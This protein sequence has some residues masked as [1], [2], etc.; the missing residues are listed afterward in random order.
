[1]EKSTGE[2][3]SWFFGDWIQTT[4]RN[5]LALVKASQDKG[6]TVKNIGN[7]PSSANISAMQGDSVLAVVDV[8]L[9]AP[10]ARSTVDAP[11]VSGVDRWVLDEERVTLD[12]DRSNNVRQVSGLFKGAEPLQ[13]RMLTRLENPDKTQVFWLPALGW[14]AHNGLMAGVTLHNMAL[15]PRDF[16]YQWTPLFSVREF[17]QGVD[18]GGILAMDWRK[19]QWHVGMRSSQFRADEAMQLRPDVSIPQYDGALLTRTSFTVERKLN[20]APASPWKGLARYEGVHVYGYVDPVPDAMWT[21]FPSSGGVRLQRRASRLE[22]AAEQR[23]TDVPGLSQQGSLL[24]GRVVTEG[25]RLDT[26]ASAVTVQHVFADAW[27]HVEYTKPRRGREHTWSLDGRVTRVGS[28]VVD[29]ELDFNWADSRNLE[30]PDFGTAVAG[31]GA[32]FDPLADQLLLNRGS[33][34]EDGWTGRQAS[35]D[36]GGLPLNMVAPQG[37]WY[38]TPWGVGL[39]AG[40]VGAW[41]DGVD[42]VGGSD[43]EA[44]SNAVLGLSLLLGP[45]EFQIPVWTAEAAEGT[46]PWEA[47]MFKLDLRNLNP[48]SLVRQN[49][50]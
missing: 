4:K 34:P 47:W 19:D 46:Q 8:P 6:L 23:S 44:V 30:N 7:L 14:N 33:S 49:L 41:G 16:T 48:L 21:L 40:A 18:F 32:H 36:R 29:P 45:L 28:Q 50:Q 25:F 20:A 12:Y 39:F 3:L 11:A 26:P 2:D 43:L 27:W 42:A 10:G 37:L 9:T 38:D 5:D 31:T 35:L 13:L 15:P 1:L 24:L 17:G 22:L